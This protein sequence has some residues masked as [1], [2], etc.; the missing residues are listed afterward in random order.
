MIRALLRPVCLAVVLAAAAPGQ[1]A[2]LDPQDAAFLAARDAFE[3]NHRTRLA[4]LAP[5]LRGHLLAPYVEYWQLFFK[6][7]GAPAGDVR[8]FLSRYSGTALAEQLRVDWLKV[9]GKSGRWE[10]FQAEYPALSGDDPEVT[11]YMLLARWKRED[12]SVLGDFKPFWNAPRELPEGCLALARAIHKSGQLGSREA[13][14]RFRVLVAAGLMGA[15]KRAMEFL[16]RGEAIDARR[17][18]AVI[19][20]PVKFL[21]NPQVDL[22]KVTDRELVIAA[23]TLAADA[24]AR[25]AAGFWGG[26]LSDAFA[27]EDRR[28]VWLILAMNGALRQVPEALDWFGE[29][30]ALTDEQ[31]GWR[32][33]IAMRTDRWAEVR[34][35]IDRMSQLA[36]N[37]PVWIYWYGRAERALGSPLEAE[38]YFERIAGEHSF[39]GRLAAEELGATLQIPARA[40][41]PTESEIAEV[42]AIPGLARA[43]ALYRLDMR[44]EATKE[45]LW[46]I[47]GMDDRKLLA[48]A[49]L[50]RR[51]EA[52]DRAIG[53]ADRT[54]LAHNFSVRYLA[55]YREVLAEKARSRDLEEPWVLAVV[56][57]ESRFITGAKSSAGATGLMQVM[58]PT[59]K[60]VAQR[61]RMKNFSSSRLHEPDL[62]AALGTYY[63]KYVLN[64]FDGS[65]VL[66]AAAYNA[67][68]TRARLWRGT[69]PVEGA[70][71]VETIPFGE[72]RDYVKKVMTNTVYYAAILGI[73]PISLKARM[74][75]VL[76]RRSSEGVAV[77]QNP[78]VVQ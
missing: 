29:P 11:C 14:E 13:W 36:K 20:A 61:M 42:A 15:A 48:A 3:A 16:P 74:G 53:T 9:L 58:R 6:L 22:A 35:S 43:L 27:V 66:A 73:E 60:W 31:L 46:T 23:L 1:A 24:D 63:L 37:D 49:E 76:P 30:G 71:F 25:A 59:A 4:T 41:L 78:P 38:G 69:A 50:A 57:Q 40:P 34:S 56:R 67:G 10:L 26:G 55:P 21:R 47:R 8:E 68:P 18:A 54:V 5:E 19:R 72:T 65:P 64:Q 44:T 2:K 75:V 51:N 12:S 7:P 17:L 70:I 52:W 33:R 45:W 39:Y 32:A 62:N 77:I 28:Y